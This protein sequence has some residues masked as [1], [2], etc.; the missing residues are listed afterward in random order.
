M[1]DTTEMQIR[2]GDVVLGEDWVGPES[3]TTGELRERRARRGL[4]TLRRSPITRKII[5]FNLIALNVLAAG[6]LYLN[7]AATALLCSGWTRLWHRQS[8][9]RT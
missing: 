4:M 8:W 3:A 1:R 5:T 6:I 2:D 9:F 7:P